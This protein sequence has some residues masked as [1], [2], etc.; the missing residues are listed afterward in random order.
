MGQEL[1]IAELEDI[2]E[3]LEIAADQCSRELLRTEEAQKVIREADERLGQLLPPDSTAF[4]IYDRSKRKT[5]YWKVTISGYV[6]KKDC[7]NIEHW[8][9]IVR[10]VLNEYEPEFLRGE[11]GDK[12]QYFLPE[13]DRYRAIKVV[14]K[15]M[16]RAKK[17]LAVVDTYLDEEIFD[18]IESLDALVDIKLIISSKKPMFLRLYNAFKATRPNIDAKECHHCHDR[19][20]VVDESE[21]WHLGT[22][23]NGVGK[24]AC[25]V[26]KITN[27]EE[28]TRFFSYFTD[29]WS[30]GTII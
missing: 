26:N 1:K 4:R 24:K 8:V 14:L 20:L 11:R 7:K 9:T 10:D 3:R 18:Y 22:S 23:I 12:D 25:M 21:V 19:F 15:I 28:R 17:K 6:D 13:G 2:L 27:P 30:Q 29:W 5:L 16:K